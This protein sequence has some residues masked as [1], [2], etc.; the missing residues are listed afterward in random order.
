LFDSVHPFDPS[1]SDTQKATYAFI[2]GKLYN[3]LAEYSPLA[4][5]NLRDALLYNANL[6]DAWNLLGE[7][8]WKKGDLSGAKSA[9]LSALEK[10]MLN[11]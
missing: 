4:E 3:V 7:C 5:S 11:V 2:R 1:L 10:V 9:F 6:I 8:L